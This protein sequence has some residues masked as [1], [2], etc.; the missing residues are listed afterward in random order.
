M[1][2]ENKDVSDELNKETLKEL[3]VTNP[4]FDS[5][6]EGKDFYN[7]L[8]SSSDNKAWGYNIDTNTFDRSIYCQGDWFRNGDNYLGFSA[9]EA[10]E[11]NET[12]IITIYYDGRPSI[13]DEERILV[14]QAASGIAELLGESENFME[15]KISARLV[16]FTSPEDRNSLLDHFDECL[17]KASEAFSE[18]RREI[19]EVE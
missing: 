14:K 19:E 4:N 3:T 6:E 16:E 7:D 18:M 5:I 2:N 15:G 10:I 17:D 12:G 1:V 11:V 8:E 13:T 9:I